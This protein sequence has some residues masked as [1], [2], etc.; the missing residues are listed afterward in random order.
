MPT[1]AV[2]RVLLLLLLTVA[3]AGCADDGDLDE[4]DTSDDPT[5]ETTFDVTATEYAFSPSELRVPAGTEVTVTLQNEGTMG[6][7]WG[8]EFGSAGTVRTDII[9]PGE[10]D[11]VSFT[12][13]EPGEYPFWCS[14]PGHRGAGME[15]TLIVE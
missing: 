10:S 6:H 11:S 1:Q 14:V 4:G 15:G 9:G 8:G 2:P 7:D 13:D 3:L 12:V 5:T